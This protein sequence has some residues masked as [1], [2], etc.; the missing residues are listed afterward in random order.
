MMSDPSYAFGVDIGG[1]SVKMGFFSAKEGLMEK[2]QLPSRTDGDSAA[3]L[4]EIADSLHARMT[5]RGLSRADILGA[6]VGVPG[7]VDAQ[8]IVHGCVNLGWGGVALKSTLETLCGF[9]FKAEN[10]ANAAA[11]GELWQGVAKG[12][13]SM[14]FLTLGTGV[15]G[16]VLLGGRP[17]SGRH[18]SAGEL[19][20]LN[21]NP[22]ET[23]VCTCGRRGCLEQYAS[24]SGLVWLAQNAMVGT[25]TLLPRE[26]FT[27]KDVF[28]TARLGDAV[29][30]HAVDSM[31]KILG[32]ALADI[33][34]V[35]DPQVF[36]LGGGLSK[37]GALLRDGVQ[38]YYSALAFGEMGDTPVEIAALQ[39]DAGIWGA[40]S[41][42]LHPLF[43]SS[44]KTA[45]F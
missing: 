42:V 8:G 44:D 27:A 21:V 12:R 20:H 17:I 2:W 3:M 39:N 34:A 36:V 32:G 1:T 7:P 37:A 4:A 38:R 25:K 45:D 18:G 28:D 29:A 22:H 16:A 41:L 31:T 26:N 9:N 5:A 13:D 14:V 19:G 43:Q 10:D 40:V 30:L 33:A 11:L 23:R 35:C 15:G 24:A 6:G